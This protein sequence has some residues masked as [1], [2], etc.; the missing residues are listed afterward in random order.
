MSVKLNDQDLNC[1]AID[2]DTA[3]ISIQNKN[4]VV[5]YSLLIDFLTRLATVA[6][7]VENAEP[8]ESLKQDFSSDVFQKGLF[9]ELH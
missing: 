3:V 6:S 5:D 7:Q 9:H 8:T 4:F 2:S 1:Y